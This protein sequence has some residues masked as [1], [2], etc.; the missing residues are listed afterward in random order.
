V[1]GANHDA[2]DSEPLVTV[3]GGSG[4]QPHVDHRSQ[5]RS[6]VFLAAVLVSGGV[7]L[8]VRVRNLSTRGALLEGGSLPQGGAAVRLVR[9]DLS[10]D[11]EVAWQ[12]DGLIGI[13]F[14]GE[15]DVARWVRRTEHAGQRRVDEAV[16]ALRLRHA[17]P[18]EPGQA[19]SLSLLNISRELDAICGRLASSL[20]MA[21]NLAEELARIDAL[22]RLIEQLD[23]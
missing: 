18:C 20:P 22:A 6:N 1:V 2:C 4:L 14:A 7:A 8:P 3:A 16:A 9:G 21:L 12:R 23:R 17:P 11:A 15:I 13:F 19:S 10:A 5:G